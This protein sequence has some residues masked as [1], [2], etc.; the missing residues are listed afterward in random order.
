MGGGSRNI[1]E[2]NRSGR[3]VSATRDDRRHTCVGLF[4]DF[5]IILMRKARGEFKLRFYFSKVNGL[6]RSASE[7][8]SSSAGPLVKV[9]NILG[10]R[11]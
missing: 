7:S 9:L 1:G 6:Y 4:S 2:T 8:S 11:G 3:I 5:I 10:L